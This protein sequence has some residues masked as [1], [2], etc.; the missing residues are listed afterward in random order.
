MA[1]VTV[2]SNKSWFDLV[3][4]PANYS[5]NVEKNVDDVQVEVEGGKDVLFRGD[6]ILVLPSQHQLRV[7]DE[8]DGEKEG[9][10]R[11]VD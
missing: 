10:Q 7:E 3:A 11:G 2:L 8:I 1:N 4:G 6:G 5:Q 9:A